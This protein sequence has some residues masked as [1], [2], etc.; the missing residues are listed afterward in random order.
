[1]TE[2][3]PVPSLLGRV[4]RVPRGLLWAVLYHG[5]QVA[6]L[7]T[8][9]LRA[10]RAATGHRHAARGPGRRTTPLAQPVRLASPPPTRPHQR[11]GNPRRAVSHR[12]GRRWVLRAVGEAAMKTGS[13]YVAFGVRSLSAATGLGCYA[14]PVLRGV[15]AVVC[16]FAPGWGKRGEVQGPTPPRK[17]PTG[18]PSPDKPHLYAAYRTIPVMSVEICRCGHE[19]AAHEHFRAGSECSLCVHKECKR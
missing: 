14:E 13:R 16:R 17:G 3:T 12:V 5:D 8:G 9:P 2:T 6:A 7:G 10:A 11:S 4:E 15:A 1:M 18:V 19:R